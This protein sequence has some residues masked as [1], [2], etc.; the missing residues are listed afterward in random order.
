VTKT[1]DPLYKEIVS[2]VVAAMITGIDNNN[3]YLDA[4]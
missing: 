3:E 4:S 2:R 1:P